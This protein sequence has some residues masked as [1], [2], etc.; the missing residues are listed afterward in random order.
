MSTP[1]NSLRRRL[2]DAR[3]RRSTNIDDQRDVDA[4][5]APIDSAGYGGGRGREV[6]KPDLSRSVPLPIDP[7]TVSPHEREVARFQAEDARTSAQT[8]ET[9]P[10][11]RKSRGLRHV[12]VRP[13]QQQ[14]EEDRGVRHAE[15]Y[16]KGIGYS[17]ASA[18]QE[19]ET[20][21]QIAQRLKGR[22]RG[23][24]NVKLTGMEN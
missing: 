24:R 12:R 22:K 17:D 6:V 20:D 14:A 7:S 11:I 5:I 23:L 16:Y 1:Q 4:G 19:A 15:Q 2:L 3:N 18:E 21:F 13:A 9:P 8:D 10:T